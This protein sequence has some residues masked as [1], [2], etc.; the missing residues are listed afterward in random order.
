MVTGEPTLTLRQLALQAIYEEHLITLQKAHQIA[1]QW[2]HQSGGRLYQLYR[3]FLRPADRLG[4]E[5]RE[6]VSLIKDIEAVLPRLTAP[7]RKRAEEELLEL[8]RK[9]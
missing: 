1:Q 9:K 5:N 4:R 2:G 7:A 8:L 6:L 3:K